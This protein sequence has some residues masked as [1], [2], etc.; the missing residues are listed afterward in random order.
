MTSD[1]GGSQLKHQV[2]NEGQAIVLSGRQELAALY[3]MQ[4]SNAGLT[5]AFLE[6][7]ESIKK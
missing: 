4:L 2:H 7:T 5:M 6:P 1:R 3:R